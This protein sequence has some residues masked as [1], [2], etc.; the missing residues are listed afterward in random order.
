MK[1]VMILFMLFTL[2]SLS[3]NAQLKEDGSRWWGGVEVRDGYILGKKTN[4][5]DG[6]KPNSNNSMGIHLIGGYYVSSSFS[7]GAGAGLDQLSNPGFS[8]MPVFLDLRFHPFS[9]NENVVI[10]GQVGTSLIN[11]DNYKATFLL[12]GSIGYS[13]KFT[14]VE[15][16]PAVGFN[17]T[18]FKEKKWN[19]D[20]HKR[21]I[22]YLKLGITI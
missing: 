15:L 18:K 9:G 8:F 5:P 10:N 13:F 14:K 6:N 3:A 22:V 16:I 1:K 17:Y 2:T 4:D 20:G 12:D 19:E 7:I 21:N 11:G